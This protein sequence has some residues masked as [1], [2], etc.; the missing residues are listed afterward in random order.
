LFKQYS[1]K[2]I[3]IIHQL[4]GHVYSLVPTAVAQH[5][6]A[7]QII[8]WQSWFRH[9]RCFAFCLCI[10]GALYLHMWY[11]TLAWDLVFV[12]LLPTGRSRVIKKFSSWSSRRP[13][14]HPWNRL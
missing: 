8:A 3:E 13:V 6:L 12:T 1:R 14:S 9:N 4:V 10:Q 2:H 7:R 11:S 5:R